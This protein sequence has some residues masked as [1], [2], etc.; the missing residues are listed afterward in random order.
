MTRSP[1]P[2]TPET[3]SSLRSGPHPGKAG[4]GSKRRLGLTASLGLALGALAAAP[5]P[6][7]AQG[8]Q[9]VSF[10]CD[11]PAGRTCYFAVQGGGAASR[12]FSLPSGRRAQI[13]GLRPGLDLYLV[14]LDAPNNG[15]LNRCRQLTVL[16]HVCQR[17]VVD[18][19]FND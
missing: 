4:C 10:G 5:A 2:L 13:G 19:S 9:A 16:G 1:R 18:S 11:A 15:D 8:A 17:K 12:L 7:F 3:G 14:S 6:G